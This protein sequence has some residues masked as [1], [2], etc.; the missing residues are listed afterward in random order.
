MNI[1]HIIL[2]II[3]LCLFKKTFLQHIR[4]GCNEYSSLSKETFSQVDRS[5]TNLAALSREDIQDLKRY[6]LS[7]IDWTKID[8][9]TYA[10]IVCI[11][12]GCDTRPIIKNFPI[13]SPN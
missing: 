9:Y 3:A 7:K 10:Q 8:D 12:Q 4:C 13:S 11:V 6:D 2:L 1:V 5:K